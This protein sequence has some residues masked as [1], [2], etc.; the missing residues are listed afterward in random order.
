[1]DGGDLT[2]ALAALDRISPAQPAYP[3]ARRLR[4]EVETALLDRG[5]EE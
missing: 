3:F 1:M 5:P 4:R 2:G